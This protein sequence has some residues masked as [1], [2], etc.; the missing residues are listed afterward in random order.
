MDSNIRYKFSPSGCSDLIVN[1][2]E[3]IAAGSQTEDSVQEISAFAATPSQLGHLDHTI[4]SSYLTDLK[5]VPAQLNIR[6][7]FLEIQPLLSRRAL[8]MTSKIGSV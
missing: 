6:R 1:H 7:Q 5:Y 3:L 8:S 2:S 4:P